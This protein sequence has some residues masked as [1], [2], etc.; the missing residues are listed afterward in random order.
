MVG[1]W[2]VIGHLGK[3]HARLLGGVDFDGLF[4]AASK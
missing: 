4:L 3:H 2:I 1:Q